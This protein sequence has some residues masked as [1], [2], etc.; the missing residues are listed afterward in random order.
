MVVKGA[1]PAPSLRNKVLARMTSE[2][3]SIADRFC[4]ELPAAHPIFAAIDHPA[5]LALMREAALKA[6]VEFAAWS[7]SGGTALTS[8][9]TDFYRAQAEVAAAQLV[10]LEAVQDPL[11]HGTRILWQWLTA[12]CGPSDTGR[13]VALSLV[14][15]LTGWETAVLR[16]L[17]D[18]YMST[19]FR[20]DADERHLKRE[21]L[22]NL[23]AGR[24]MAPHVVTRLAAGFGLEA[25]GECL[26]LVAIPGPDTTG[27]EV[28]SAVDIVQQQSV[29]SRRLLA[30]HGDELVSVVPNDPEL[31]DVI[32]GC[33]NAVEH[34]SRIHAIRLVVGI[35]SPGR[36]DEVPDRYLEAK[37][38]LRFA[39]MNDDTVTAMSRVRLFDYLATRFD[40]TARRMVPPEFAALVHEDSRADGALRATL[41]ALADNDLNVGRTAKSLYVHANTVHYRLKRI[42]DITGRNPRSFRDLSDLLV[43]FAGSA[44]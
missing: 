43:A 30:E 23:L 25:D 19:R 27:A 21:I 1:Q 5:L 15:E 37:V 24:T 29:G 36:L 35:S 7:T 12:A 17:T 20:A 2:A 32:A 41:F 8:E 44:G 34:L 39:V 18:A 42:A 14:E 38:A 9:A 11:Q 4:A 22:D 13:E 33:R 6:V 26:V 31:D 16:T 28:R 10:P 40:A 3:D